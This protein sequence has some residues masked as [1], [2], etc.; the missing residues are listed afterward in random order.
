MVN[1]F[2][3]YPGNYTRSYIGK[4][5]VDIDVKWFCHYKLN[6]FESLT[7]LGYSKLQAFVDCLVRMLEYYINRRAISG[8]HN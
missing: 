6:G 1:R 4:D 2:K 3:F 8:N 7:G 5:R